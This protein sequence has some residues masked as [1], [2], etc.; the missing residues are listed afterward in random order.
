MKILTKRMK[1]IPFTV[2]IIQ[3]A[4]QHDNKQLLKLGITPTMGW[5]EPDLI[6][7]LPYFNQQIID[8][9]VTG[10]NSWLMLDKRTNEIIG[11]LGFINEPDS[12]G[13]VEM[14]FGV[15]R[16]RWRQGYCEEAIIALITWV[17]AKSE[18]KIVTAQCNKDNKKSINLLMKIGFKEKHSKNSIL[19]WEYVINAH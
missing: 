10:Y 11:S 3:A 8:H 4:I 7:A 14:G 17:S 13:S 18:V 19:N 2:E 1:L 12:S 6:E 9:G 15:V 16:T 5:P